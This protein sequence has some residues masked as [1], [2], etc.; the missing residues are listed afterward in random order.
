MGRFP[1]S[2][3]VVIR[4]LPYTEGEYYR[5]DFV[6]NSIRRSGYSV[7]LFACGTVSGDEEQAIGWEISQSIALRLLNFLAYLMTIRSFAHF[8][9]LLKLWPSLTAER[10][11]IVIFYSHWTGLF[12]LFL[13]KLT[14]F[15]VRLVWEWYD[16][17]TRMR[18]YRQKLGLAGRIMLSLE[19][20]LAPDCFDG[21]IVPTRFAKKL[22]HDWGHPVSKI[23]VLGEVRELNH[24]VDSL[25]LERRVEEVRE[26]GPLHITWVGA[27]RHYQ[28]DGL[29]MFLR[30]LRGS[31]RLG[32]GMVIH[33]A[34]PTE[35]QMDEL[36][37]MAK[38]MPPEITVRWHGPL[39]SDRMDQ[40]LADSHLAIHP[41]PHELFCEYIYSRKMAD[42]LAS[43]LPVA[44]SAVEGL[45]EVGEGAGVQF[46]LDD[47]DSVV[48]AIQ[49]LSDPLPY[50]E[51][52][53]RAW[54]LAQRE[55]HPR[56]LLRK[57]E[58]LASFLATTPDQVGAT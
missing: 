8:G 32:R 42:Y 3:V 25:S 19:E 55:F 29:V 53:Q 52:S 13:R 58:K 23:H 51:F 31:L 11:T 47:R 17:S 45:A 18:F 16:L 30:H 39:S 41:V 44:F 22:L 21:L 4:E 20:R 49:Q 6:M 2:D 36:M 37:A 7:R 33:V 24:Y 50:I 9:F 54:Q 43:S 28:L 12:L 40:L 35:M 57:G 27:I 34:G 48:G 46:H 1:L 56:A 5:V 10:P 14:G 15:Q 26:N 38:S